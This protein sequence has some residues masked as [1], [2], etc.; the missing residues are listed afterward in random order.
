MSRVAERVCSVDGCGRTNKITRGMCG[1]HYERFRRTG[2]AGSGR[3]AVYTHGGA[4]CDESGCEREARANGLCVKHY[5]EARRRA[6]GVSAKG[7]R[8][9]TIARFWSKVDASG[10]EDACWPW[11]TGI[12][13]DGYGQFWAY[14]ESIHAHRFALMLTEQFDGDLVVDHVCHNGSGCRDNPCHHR[15]CCN[16][17]H[18]EAVTLAENTRRGNGGAWPREKTHCPH[19]HEYNVENT[20]R[21]KDGRRCRTCVNESNRKQREKR[22]A[23]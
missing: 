8:E 23:A 1:T 3:I 18:L 9:S 10:G 22:K 19:G 11:M 13:G 15:R 6:R 21:T 16:P 14:G 2:G 17:R 20:L 5:S 12:D 7:T 4:S